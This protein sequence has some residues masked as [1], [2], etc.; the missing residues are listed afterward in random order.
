MYKKI[1]KIVKNNLLGF[2]FGFT[3]ISLLGVVSAATLY[4]STNLSY[5]APANMGLSGTN[6]Q[7]ALDSLYNLKPEVVHYDFGDPTT[8]STTDYTELV[9]QGHNTFVALYEDGSKAA[10]VVRNG[11]LGCFKAGASN[12]TKNKF[13]IQGFFSDISCDVFSNNV[14]CDDGDASCR[15]DLN[16]DVYSDDV[17]AREYCEINASGSV[18]CQ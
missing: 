13:Y 10:C 2:V 18:E 7:Q 15:V 14:T 17:V 6:V 4:N 1:R 5:T 9:A 16:G 3:F 8:S 12:W 11:E